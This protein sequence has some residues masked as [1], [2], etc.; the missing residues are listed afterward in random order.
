MWLY[1]HSYTTWYSIYS[2]CPV[3]INWC[4]RDRSFDSIRLCVAIGWNEPCEWGLGKAHT[5]AKPRKSER[6]DRKARRDVSQSCESQRLHRVGAA[7]RA[8][9]SGKICLT[10]S[11]GL[12]LSQQDHLAARASGPAMVLCLKGRKDCQSTTTLIQWRSDLIVIRCN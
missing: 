8:C 2:G 9:S 7:C 10:A 12:E 1:I 4:A 3:E 5:D 6:K 11:W